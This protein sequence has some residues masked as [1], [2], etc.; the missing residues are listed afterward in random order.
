MAPRKPESSREKADRYFRVFLG[1]VAGLAL[2]YF[3]VVLE[4]FYLG[5][6]ALF[7]RLVRWFPHF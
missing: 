3:L 4:A 6:D 2:I 5:D 7:Y 1:V